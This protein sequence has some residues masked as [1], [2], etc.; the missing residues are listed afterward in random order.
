MTAFAAI[1]HSSMIKHPGGKA[2]YDM[3]Y[4]TVFCGR[5][6]VHRLADGRRAIVA[7][8]AV[9]TARHRLGRRMARA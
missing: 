7:G 2:A 1:D 3:T 9:K 4:G 6:M 5:N 8:G